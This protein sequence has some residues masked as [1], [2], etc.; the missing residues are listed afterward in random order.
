MSAVLIF[1]TNTLNFSRVFL[2][3]MNFFRVFGLKKPPPFIFRPL[4]FSYFLVK[5]KLTEG[6]GTFKT[7]RMP[8]FPLWLFVFHCLSTTVLLYNVTLCCNK[9]VMFVTKFVMIVTKFVMIVSIFVMA[10]RSVQRRLSW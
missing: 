3:T 7:L 8:P 2:N 5:K 9:F 1:A 6:P 10:H 4:L